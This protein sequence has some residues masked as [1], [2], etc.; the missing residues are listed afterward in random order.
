M[1]EI[2][3]RADVEDVL[4]I[5][6]PETGELRF[7]ITDSTVDER[8]CARCGTEIS[9]YDNGDVTYACRCHAGWMWQSTFNQQHKGV[10]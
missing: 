4:K 2:Q 8:V 3:V 1:P 5:A 7:R 10:E 6:H 9:F